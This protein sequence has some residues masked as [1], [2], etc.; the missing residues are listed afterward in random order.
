MLMM[1]CILQFHLG[2]FHQQLKGGFGVTN[3]LYPLFTEIGLKEIPTFDQ[4][5]FGEDQGH[6]RSLQVKVRQSP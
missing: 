6:E 1:M 4:I 5:V 2:F 3:I